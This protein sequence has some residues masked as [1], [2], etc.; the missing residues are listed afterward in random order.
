MNQTYL[1]IQGWMIS[2]L[3]LSG[4][5]LILYAIIYGF[6]QDGFNKFQGSLSYLSQWTGASKEHIC[7][8]LKKMCDDG[9][10]RK[11]ESNN[12]GPNA[13][14]AILPIPSAGKDTNDKTSAQPIDST[15]PSLFNL[16]NPEP[17]SPAAIT[18]EEF[19]QF[20]KEYTPVQIHGRMVSKG[21]KKLAQER[22]IVARKKSTADEILDGLHRYLNYCQKNL[23]LTCQAAVFLSQERW[24]N[25][26]NTP[27]RVA[28]TEKERARAEND[29]ALIKAIYGGVQ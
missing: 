1:T 20:W 2:E 16:E 25:E 10:I 22:Y 13:Y 19:E 14:S 7:R 15:T 26:Y 17:E 6:S 18:R 28:M 11:T 12:G 29:E 21:P 4:H 24:K 5:E 9:L 27:V 8:L 23:I 3:G